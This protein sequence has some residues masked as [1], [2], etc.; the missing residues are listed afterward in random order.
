MPIDKSILRKR[1]WPTPS[2]PIGQEVLKRGVGVITD[3]NGLALTPKAGLVYAPTPHPDDYLESCFAREGNVEAMPVPAPAGESGITDLAVG[4]DG[5]I[6]G[7]T[8]GSS[9]HLF[10]Y[11][12]CGKSAT[13]LAL[14][15][16]SCG[17][18]SLAIDLHGRLIIGLKTISGESPLY[19]C[20][21]QDTAPAIHMEAFP[22]AKGEGVCALA[23]DAD[24]GFIYGL[25]SPSGVL[26]AFDPR[27]Q[28]VLRICQVDKDARFSEALVAV[29]GKGVFGGGRWGRLFQASNGSERPRFSTMATPSLRGKEMYNSIESLLWEPGANVLYGGTSA[30]GLLFRANPASLETRCLGKIL[31][32]PHIR[33]LAASTDG[34]VYGI[35]GKNCC[36]LFRHTPATGELKDLGLLHVDSPRPW[37][38]YE[39]SSAVTGKDGRIYLGENDRISHLFVYTP[40][41]K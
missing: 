31:A 26:F 37:H 24:D 13:R 30:D 1:T 35:A 34:D 28:S 8:C 18:A 20:D 10:S 21:P 39:F 38:G 40:P 17:K 9:C 41:G 11:D 15:P 2:F 33:C 27:R 12:P 7:A 22:A 6:Y 3:D 29:P 36:H 14:I 32:Q 5:T 16:R 19:S 25:T 23:L 4:A